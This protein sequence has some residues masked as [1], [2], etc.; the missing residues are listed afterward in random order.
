VIERAIDTNVLLWLLARDDAGQ[1]AA[2]DAFVA[3]GAWVSQRVLVE[4]VCVL[5]AVYGRTPRQLIAAPDGLLSRRP[6]SIQ[7]SETVAAASAH[8]KHRPSPG[9]SNCLALEVARQAGHGPPG[10]FDKALA[11]LP[12]AQR[13]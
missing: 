7:D 11:T 6:L 2:A 10:T 8:F 13:L 12:Q 4:T 9:F 5:S 3:G 1:A